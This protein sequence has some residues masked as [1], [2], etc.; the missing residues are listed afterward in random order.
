MHVM[1]NFCSLLSIALMLFSGIFAFGNPARAADEEREMAA[2]CAASTGGELLLFTAC[3]GE[4][5]TANEIVKFL[6]G[7]EFF[8]CGN[9]LRKIFDPCSNEGS[10]T[11][12]FVTPYRQGV[13]LI[14][15]DGS[16]HDGYYSPDG[17][18]LRGG[19]NTIQNYDGRQYVLAIVPYRDRLWTAFDG[20][21]IYRSSPRAQ[22]LSPADGL[23]YNGGAKVR[24]MRA[25]GSR[26]ETCFMGHGCYCSED[27]MHPGGGPRTVNGK[28]E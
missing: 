1:R 12:Y 26:L 3:M 17:K 19:G 4:G 22:H 5:L 24:S 20:G 18:N 6:T 27:G 10:P 8:G 15:G 25:V 21:G 9:E 28:C 14:Y 13:V 7:G 16:S 11:P 23:L 2:R